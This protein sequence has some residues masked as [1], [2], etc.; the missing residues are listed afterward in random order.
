M[1]RADADL[2]TEVGAKAVPDKVFAATEADN[3]KL[4]NIHVPGWE[5]GIE[6]IQWH[7]FA[8]MTC[9]PDRGPLRAA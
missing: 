3:A 4:R 1:G 5:V 6:P 9:A 7:E 2:P 8:M